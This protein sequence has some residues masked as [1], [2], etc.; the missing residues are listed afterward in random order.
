MQ[1][2]ADN[3]VKF[4][5]H[6]GVQILV[7]DAPSQVVIHVRDSCSGLSPEELATIFEPFNRAH[8][9]KPGTGLG[10]AIA[11]RAATAQGGSFRWNQAAVAVIFG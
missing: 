3:A 7:E 8:P 4:T 2:L 10:L 11:K 6:G 5:D 9:G 1:N